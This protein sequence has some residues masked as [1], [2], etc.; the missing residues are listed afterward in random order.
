MG[1]LAVRRYPVTNRGEA[2]MNALSPLGRAIALLAIATVVALAA[3][4]T[5][6]GVWL[7]LSGRTL[8]NF[9][10]WLA[11]GAALALLLAVFLLW[12]VDRAEDGS[13]LA[14]L[15][16]SSALVALVFGVT[17]LVPIWRH[18]G[19]RTDR[20]QLW[21]IIVFAALA[22]IA[23]GIMASWV[24]VRPLRRLATRASGI[25]G[26]HFEA[27]LPEAGNTEIAQLTTAINLLA[28]RAQSSSIRQS[29]QDRARESLLLAIAA[30]AQ[31]P[32]DAIRSI[33]QSMASGSNGEPV[34]T[35]RH[36]DAIDRET[37]S[38]QRR[39]D[40]VEEIAQLES[41]QV[42]LRMQP[43]SLAQLVIAVCDRL[44]PGAATRNVILGP[45]V[46]FSAPRVLADP[47][48]TLRALEAFVSYA[49][50]ETPDSSQLAVEMR[51]SG[52]F[53]Q[54]A[55]LELPG[56]NASDVASRVRWE[57][58]HRR[59]ESALSLAVAGRLIEI[60]GGSFLISR[61]NAGAPMVVVSLPRS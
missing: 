13:Y 3:I 34:A 6:A 23:F 1:G 31:V 60:Q 55:A 27:R 35:R 43:V 2:R 15:S 54:V 7:D 18:A 12:V 5:I 28:S 41:G 10:G 16:L 20:G 26:G 8:L 49:L 14:R 58:A 45:H 50:A 29:N 42:T 11:A 39:I 61:G 52:Q 17:A 33:T 47:D 21:L 44:H 51:E 30:D 24:D 25:A 36:L 40:E 37:A 53:V 56:E 46:D 48:Q 38:L 4:V 59:R 19:S 9:A 22:S 57:S 32:I